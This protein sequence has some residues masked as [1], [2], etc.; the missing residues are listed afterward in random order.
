M[1]SFSLSHVSAA[2]R[3]LFRSPR[4]GHRVFAAE[5]LAAKQNYVLHRMEDS[6]IRM[7]DVDLTS[8][9]LDPDFEMHTWILALEVDSSAA[10][11]RQYRDFLAILADD[12]DARAY[13]SSNLRVGDFE[14]LLDAVYTRMRAAV[15]GRRE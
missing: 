8:G 12:N 9:P 6:R 2:A 10:V 11:L 1:R 4:D 15:E 7:T 5:F 14:P 3:H 13:V